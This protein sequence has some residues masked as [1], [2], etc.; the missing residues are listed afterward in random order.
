MRF[1]SAERSVRATA[2]LLVA[3]FVLIGAVLL[4]SS[5]AVAH[6]KATVQEVQTFRVVPVGETAYP[7]VKIWYDIPTHYTAT[8]VLSI[9]IS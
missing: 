9:T 2:L 5:A 1:R 8:A 7:D 4:P 6:Q 3:L